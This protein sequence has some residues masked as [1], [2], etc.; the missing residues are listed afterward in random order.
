MNTF[1]RFVLGNAR[2]SLSTLR[3]RNVDFKLVAGNEFLIK[4]VGTKAVIFEQHDI[5]D[6]DV[7]NLL[8]VIPVGIVH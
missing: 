4:E 6:T 5:F 1:L 8:V 2:S 7:N 3:K